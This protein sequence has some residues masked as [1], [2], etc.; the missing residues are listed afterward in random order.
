M[1]LILT[2]RYVDNAIL[3]IFL[4]FDLGSLLSRSSYAS[5]TLQ[6]SFCLVGNGID[7][8]G[9]IADLVQ[10]GLHSLDELLLGLMRPVLIAGMMYIDKN[11][12]NVFSLLGGAV[13]IDAC[14]THEFE[15]IEQDG[16]S[17]ALEVEGSVTITI[18]GRSGGA[19]GTGLETLYAGLF[20]GWELVFQL[21][22]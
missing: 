18:G 12:F 6:Y 13:R 9:L 1:I 5:Q 10:A 11:G 19:V 8:R 17:E 20:E 3:P 15:E 14:D 22:G 7:S 4:S 2:H 16:F 21:N